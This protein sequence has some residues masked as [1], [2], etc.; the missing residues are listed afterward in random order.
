VGIYWLLPMESPTDT[1][2]RWFRRWKCHVTALISRFESF[3]HSIGKIIWKKFTS[4]HRCNF[5]KKVYSPSVYTDRFWDEIIS[6]GKYYQR[7]NFVGNF[8]GFRRISGSDMINDEF[9]SQK[10]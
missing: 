5:P 1:F 9:R 7:K 10:Y 2:C 6:V 8:V 4:S 3:N